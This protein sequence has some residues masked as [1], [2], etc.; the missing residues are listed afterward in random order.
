MM[1]FKNDLIQEMHYA[2]SISLASGH[3]TEATYQV[4]Y[5]NYQKNDF[6]YWSSLSALSFFDFEEYYT[7]EFVT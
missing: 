4:R 3:Y 5:N 1:N 6:W 7:Q 2:T